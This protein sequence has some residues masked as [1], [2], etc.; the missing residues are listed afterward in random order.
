MKDKTKYKI[1]NHIKLWLLLSAV[2]LFSYM[3]DDPFKA[4]VIT[5]LILILKE[6]VTEVQA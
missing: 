6:Q 1:C 4:A 5:L 2:G 3:Y